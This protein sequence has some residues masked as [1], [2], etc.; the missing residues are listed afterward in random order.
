MSL[1]V[2]APSNEIGVDVLVELDE[3]VML[4]LRMDMMVIL[5]MI[6]VLTFA[7]VAEHV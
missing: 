2:P 6:V 1:P 4:D 3:V 7:G 5:V